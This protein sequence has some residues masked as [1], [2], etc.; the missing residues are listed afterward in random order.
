M[1]V[2]DSPDVDEP[3]G[4]T[5]TASFVVHLAQRSEKPIG[6][7]YATS[8]GSALVSRGDYTTTT[9]HLAIA[10]DRPLEYADI[11]AAVAEAGYALH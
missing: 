7:D 2:S 10:H 8:D 4:S 6:L 5:A 9:G 3:T 11:A 1:T